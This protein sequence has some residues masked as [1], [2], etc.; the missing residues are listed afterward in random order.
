MNI[1]LTSQSAVVTGASRGIGLAVIRALVASGAHV[2]AGVRK[3]SAE[4]DKLAADGSVQV[5]EADLATPAGPARLVA[6]AG[7]RID[8]LVNN[9]GSAPART[10]GF[11]AITD[12]EWLATLNINLMSAVRATRAALPA[13]LAAGKG[14]IVNMCSVNSV[15]SDPFVI[16]Y[17]TAKAGLAS[18]SKALS[19]EVGAKGVRVNTISPGPVATDLWFGNQGVAETV[20]RATASGR[21]RWHARPPPPWSPV[22]SAPRKRSPPWWWFWPATSRPT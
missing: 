1:D 8:I 21:K 20:G 9:V 2:T 13:M 15:L 10:S 6:T 5:V 22:G 3:S 11:L 14:V 19:K 17:S 4:L 7:D 18:F 12:E 16:D